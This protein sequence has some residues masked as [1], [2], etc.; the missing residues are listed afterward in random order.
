MVNTKGIQSINTRWGIL[1][2]NTCPSPSDSNK[3]TNDISEFGSVNPNCNF[4]IS[5]Y[6]S[7]NNI[8]IQP[9]INQCIKNLNTQILNTNNK[10][11]NENSTMPEGAEFCNGR[12]IY[13]QI[14]NHCTSD[15]VNNSNSS[16]QLYLSFDKRL[17][18]TMK[19]TI[20]PSDSSHIKIELIQPNNQVT[21]VYKDKLN[22]GD[23]N[24][25]KLFYQN[26]TLEIKHNF[27]LNFYLDNILDTTSDSNPIFLNWFE[28]FQGI[29]SLNDLKSIQNN[30]WE[31]QDNIIARKKIENTTWEIQKNKEGKYNLVGTAFSKKSDD[32]LTG[33]SPETK[34]KYFNTTFSNIVNDN[35]LA[36]DKINCDT[37]NC[38]LSKDLQSE[39]NTNNRRFYKNFY[40]DM[41]SNEKILNCHEIDKIKNYC[42]DVGHD[43]PNDDKLKDIFDK[44]VKGD[45]NNQ[46][47]GDDITY[48]DVMCALAY[49]NISNNRSDLE[50]KISDWWLKNI[51][52]EGFQRNIYH[53]SLLIVIIL[54]FN[55]LKKFPLFSS[56]RKQ[57][58]LPIIC[59][60]LTI[61]FYFLFIYTADNSDQYLTTTTSNQ[62]E[63]TDEQNIKT[64]TYINL[65]GK[66]IY[67]FVGFAIICGY[68]I[69]IKNN[70]LSLTITEPSIFI[71]YIIF[72]A[73]FISLF[74]LPSLNLF[75]YTF[76]TIG[77]ILLIYSNFISISQNIYFKFSSV[78]LIIFMFLSY[79]YQSENNVYQSLYFYTII[80][81]ITITIIISQKK[82]SESILL[83]KLLNEND[84]MSKIIKI[85]YVIFAIS[86]SYISILSPQLSLLITI[87]FRIIIGYWF[88]PIN[89]IFASLSE[90]NMSYNTEISN[91]NVLGKFF[92]FEK[93]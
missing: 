29:T 8:E 14:V 54:K 6:I 93:L 26:N 67:Y 52:N 50:E 61:M 89:C 56:S 24:P 53:I 3:C 43:K 10:L 76:G 7:D 62:N 79:V 68:G 51:Y 66:Y 58:I 18:N 2:N 73:T 45:Y 23:T 36:T 83:N 60:F 65:F 84:V 4:N 85:L 86:D 49:S 80:Y 20:I 35:Y 59:I 25:R 75:K 42:K 72:V 39:L 12:D 11:Y 30:T 34:S 28:E 17:D 90:Y 44:F 5:K 19:N 78:I 77:I 41:Q 46:E 40:N 92:N 64:K 87:L 31:V 9:Q 32:N 48:K 27:V 71:H 13:K 63:D 37:N 82:T 74:I 81:F 55:I 21:Q 33:C 47:L 22:I 15:N 16:Y 70:Y 57:Y 88:E 69:F 38:D 91:S 1:Q